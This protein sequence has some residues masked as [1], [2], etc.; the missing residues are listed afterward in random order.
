MDWMSCRVVELGV[1]TESVESRVH[2]LNIHFTE[3][4][5]SVHESKWYAHHTLRNSALKNFR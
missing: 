1:I 3:E 4:A 2:P 5:I